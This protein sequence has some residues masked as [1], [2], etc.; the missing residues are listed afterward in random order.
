MGYYTN[1][2]FN[3]SRHPRPEVGRSEIPKR[4]RIINPAGKK[5]YSEY[6][7]L[8]SSDRYKK[9]IDKIEAETQAGARKIFDRRDAELKPLNEKFDR[10]SKNVKSAKEYDELYDQYR[11]KELKILDKYSK[12]LRNS[13]FS[14]SRK[15]EKFRDVAVSELGFDDIDEGRDVVKLFEKLDFDEEYRRYRGPD[16]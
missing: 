12:E 8:V 5:R 13:E 10:D 9:Q 4:R 6:K 7:D 3:S 14:F 16:Y 2:L 15:M 1:E 11:K